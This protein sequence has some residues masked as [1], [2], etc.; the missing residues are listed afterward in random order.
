MEDEPRMFDMLPN[1]INFCCDLRK[2]LMI[3]LH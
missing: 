2:S 1:L 3:I